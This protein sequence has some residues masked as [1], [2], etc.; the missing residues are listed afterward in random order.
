MFPRRSPSC[1][2]IYLANNL[3]EVRQKLA[4]MDELAVRKDS[5]PHQVPALVFICNGLDIEEQQ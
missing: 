2:H 4:E 1:T 5:S 3:A